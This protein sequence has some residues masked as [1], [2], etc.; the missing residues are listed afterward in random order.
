M[1][2]I[3]CFHLPLMSYCTKFHKVLLFYT[4]VL[5]QTV[6]A[7]DLLDP[8]RASSSIAIVPYFLCLVEYSREDKAY[9]ADDNYLEQ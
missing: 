1:G 4:V 2:F 9:I 7:E 6:A 8:G 5:H 3:F